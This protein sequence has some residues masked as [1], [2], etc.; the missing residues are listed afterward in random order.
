MSDRL[1]AA[2]HGYLETLQLKA[3][4]LSSADRELYLDAALHHSRRLGR[5][6]GDLFELAK[7]DAHA[8][9]PRHE[10][11]PAAELLQDIAQKYQ[12]PARE[13]RIRFMVRLPAV[14]L[15]VE[16]DIGL[17]ERVL[18]NLILNALYHT[19]PEG[20]VALELRVTDETATFAITDTGHGIAPEDL[21][22]IFDRFYRGSSK[23]KD[24]GNHLGLG[25]DI[26]KR[27]VELHGSELWVASTLN[28]GTRFG[29]DLPIRAHPAP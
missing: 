27:I 29:F 19:P 5:L 1:L 12:L 15:F 3:G 2:L 4:C 6:V 14:K 8:I 28:R 26:A 23:A 20:I 17:L 11:F 22:H 24:D 10:C 25:L 13:H 18:D 21:P 7:L 16:A 9:Q